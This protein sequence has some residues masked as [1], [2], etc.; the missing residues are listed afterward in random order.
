MAD[1][2]PALK[3]RILSA[4]ILA[5]AVLALEI[6]GTWSFDMLLAAGAVLLAFEWRHLIAAW[7]DQRA[8]VVAG[9]AAGASAVLVLAL[10]ALGRFELAFS[11]VFICAAIAGNRRSC[12]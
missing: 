4:V 8:G 12:C 1:A 7:F 11:A 10:A 6:L 3:R 5:P 9:I 2:D